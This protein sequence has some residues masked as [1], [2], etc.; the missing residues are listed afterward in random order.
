MPD[1]Q[2][3]LR[4]FCAR[5]RPLSAVDLAERRLR[6]ADQRLRRALPPGPR[7]LERAETKPLQ[8][9]TPA[10]RP[11]RCCGW[12]ARTRRARWCLSQEGSK[13]FV[14]GGNSRE[15]GSRRARADPKPARPR[16]PVRLGPRA[17]GLGGGR[18]IHHSTYVV[19]AWCASRT[20][21]LITNGSYLNGHSHSHFKSKPNS[22]KP[23]LDQTQPT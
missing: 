1:V 18:G 5:V 20:A 11:L 9:T 22:T 23:N 4:P 15:A 2:P 14:P 12:S 10:A 21:Y 17:K 7:A 3:D 16:G 13:H 19:C 8:L 6:R